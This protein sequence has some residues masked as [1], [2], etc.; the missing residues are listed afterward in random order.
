MPRTSK[1]LPRLITRSSS[2]HAAGCYTLDPIAR[3]SRIVEYDG[4]RLSKE[5][6]DDRYAGRPVTYL[7]GYGE[8]GK[9][10]D[11]FGTAMFINHS[12]APNCET[13]ERNERIYIDAIR[14]IAAGEELL[15]EYHLYD[16]EEEHQNCY[17][18]APNCRGTM[19]SDAE[20]ARRAAKAV[21]EK[22]RK[23]RSSPA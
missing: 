23:A 22:R 21:R 8:E 1:S 7:F 3:G 14:D 12:C 20:L 16:S 4:E 19:F 5:A 2:I 17:C 18:G 9:V 11:G 6:A 10:I 15:Y 13:T